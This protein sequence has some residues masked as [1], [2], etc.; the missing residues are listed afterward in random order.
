MP[1]AFTDILPLFLTLFVVAA[2]L[3]NLIKRG[4]ETQI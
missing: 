1:L 4:D 3:Y 2:F